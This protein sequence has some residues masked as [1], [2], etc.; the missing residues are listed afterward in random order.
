MTTPNLK[1]DID[2]NAQFTEKEQAL[3]SGPVMERI[4]SQK[5]GRKA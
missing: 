1:Q 5:M 2:T 3:H 4:P